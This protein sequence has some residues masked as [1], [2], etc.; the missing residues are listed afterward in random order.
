MKPGRTEL[1]GDQ[2]EKLEGEDLLRW[3]LAQQAS[4][5]HR[6]REAPSTPVLRLWFGL[7]GHLRGS[8]PIDTVERTADKDA[9]WLCG[10]VHPGVQ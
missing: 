7:I 1:E 10:L 9:Q 2:G 8:K 3:G 4:L 6:E 5:L